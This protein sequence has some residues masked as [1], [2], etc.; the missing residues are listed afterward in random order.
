MGF[1]SEGFMILRVRRSFSPGATISAASYLRPFYGR[2]TAV[3][4]QGV[5]IEPLT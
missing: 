4:V 1:A 3:S 5:T 2:S